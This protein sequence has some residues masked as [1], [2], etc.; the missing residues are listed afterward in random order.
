M[1]KVMV[2][3]TFDGIHAG[4]RAF[5]REAKNQGDYLIAV[6]APDHAATHL[7]GKR[8]SLDENSRMEELRREAG[9]DE[10]VLGDA[11]LDTWEV[12]SVHKPQIIALGYDQAALKTA[13]E[14]NSARTGE[15]FK[16]AVMRPYEPH[17]YHTSLLSAN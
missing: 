16:L 9:V 13:L 6:V 2:F 4:H 1:R 15:H 12:L 5:L 3:G 8:P 11:E 10:V 14:A 7:K 17:K